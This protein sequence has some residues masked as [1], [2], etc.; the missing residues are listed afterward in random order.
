MICHPVC[1]YQKR[2]ELLDTGW[3][4]FCAHPFFIIFHHAIY[5][6][7]GPWGDRFPD[8]PEWCPVE[9]FDGKLLP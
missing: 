5:E 2:V 3:Y 8:R 6:K 4:V 7:V 1:P 9:V